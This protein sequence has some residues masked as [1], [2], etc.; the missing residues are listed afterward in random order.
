MN[1]GV[2]RY[3]RFTRTGA[4]ADLDQSIGPLGEAA[5]IIPRDHLNYAPMASSFSVAL[6][7]R[8]ERTAGLADLDQAIEFG[9]RAVAATPQG[10]PRLAGL[11]GNLGIA[12]LTRF[13]RCG[14]TS[15]LV[16]AVSLLR[17]AVAGMAPSHPDRARCLMNLAGALELQADHLGMRADPGYRPGR[18]RRPQVAGPVQPLQPAAHHRDGLGTRPAHRQRRSGDRDERLLPRAVA[19]QASAQGD[20][21]IQNR[22]IDKGDPRAGTADR[23]GCGLLWDLPLSRASQADMRVVDGGLPLA[24]LERDSRRPA[25]HRRRGWRPGG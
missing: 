17:E 12:W 4:M 19:G 7:A 15:D 23:H 6:C 2:A 1:L 20:D 24:I 21:G 10:H 22:Q 9:A 16:S 25:R 3:A 13:E 11:V 14:D 5:A 8:S 18:P